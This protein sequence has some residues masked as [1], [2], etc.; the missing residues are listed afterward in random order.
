[1]SNV[2]PLPSPMCTAA[3]IYARRGWPV[4]PCRERPETIVARAAD[5][6]QERVLPAKSPYGGKG[7]LNRAT[8]DERTIC[9]WWRKWPNALIGLPM[10]GATGM[11]ALDFDPRHDPDTGEVFT[12]EQLKAALEQQIGAPLPVSLASRTQSGGVHVFYRQPAG[13]PIRNRGNLPQHVDVRGLGGYVIAP[14]S[15]MAEEAGAGRYRWLAGRQDSEP[16]DAPAG[17]IEILRAPKA[18]APA[19]D[20]GGGQPPS[21]SRV[22][23]AGDD[24]VR[25]AIERYGLAALQ[26]ECKAV[27]EAGSGARNAQLNTSALKI[28]ALTVSTPFAALDAGMARA[29]I[30]AAA[31]A[32]P[33]RDDDAQLLATIASG[34]TAGLASPR[35]LGDVQRQ[36][37]ERTAR[38]ADRAERNRER[39][40]GRID[41][42]ADPP[43]PKSETNGAPSSRSGASGGKGDQTGGGGALDRECAYLPLTDL[44][45]SERFRKRFGHDFLWVPEWGWLAWDGKRWNRDMADAM[46][47][48][49]VY[50]TVRAIG[51][52]AKLIRD[53]G[54]KDWLFDIVDGH[55][56]PATEE[57]GRFDFV[58]RITRQREFLFS[59]DIA[60]WGRSS[61]AASRLGCIASLARPYMS[62]RPADF[63]SDPMKIN[64]AN[65]TMTFGTD[66]ATGKPAFRFAAGGFD[67]DDLITKIASV[68]YDPQARCPLYDRFLARVQPDAEMRGFLHRWGGYNLTGS[69]TSQKMALFYG[70]G[71]NGKSTWVDEVAFIMG[72]YA[73]S[74]GIETF[75]DQGRHRKGGD[76][77]PDLAALSGARMVRTSEPEQGA[78]FSDGLIK[79]MT[80]GE[81]MNVRELNKGFF[82]M[83]VTFK[84]TCSANVKPL[85]GTDHGIKRRV[86]LIPW[87]III[88]EDERDDTLLVKLK[89]EGSGVLNYLVDGALRW[90]ADGLP[91]PQAVQDATRE[92]QEENDPVGRFVE[93]CVV[94]TAGE[95][96]QASALYDV[97]KAWQIASGEL[98]A[99]GKPWSMKYLGSQMKKKGYRQVQNNTMWWLDIATAKSVHD[100][101]DSE[102]KPLRGGEPGL[103]PPSAR[104]SAAD[105]DFNPFDG[106]PP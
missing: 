4:F 78:K 5:G 95:R 22:S 77:T 25:V 100:F 63:D 20:A 35:D 62:A 44:G 80:G 51:G 12:L 56:V 28:A 85:I 57:R 105:D 10:G 27:R 79:A 76:A 24:P 38:A 101:V 11:F 88:P 73:R 26:A 41:P 8:T 34:W 31:R 39:A 66:P 49:A 23:R 46:V 103:D 86:R 9:D 99:S 64:L 59:D 104:L 84:V 2:T 93:L 96:V 60:A 81:P 15:V 45:N 3:L 50:D 70:E 106:M 98:P 82:E 75:I 33:G 89:A 17:L 65:G 71:A 19:D 54:R 61:E 72:E 58:T 43:A 55:A 1:M 102:W 21:A 69:I 32:N 87:D 29:S 68:D 16:V 94:K 30:E 74:C 52:E 14:P 37:A 18:R 91:E 48:R 90:M 83:V 42:P 36:I 13:D 47:D 7:G 40:G 67:R 92:Y 53:S 97:F 6:P